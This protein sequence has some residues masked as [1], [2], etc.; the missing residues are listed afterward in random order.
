M[1]TFDQGSTQYRKPWPPQTAVDALFVSGQLSI[2]CLNASHSVRA[3]AVWSL[4]AN[5]CNTTTSCSSQPFRHPGH[6]SSVDNNKNSPGVDDEQALVLLSMT[7]V[8]T[9]GI[10]FP[11][12]FVMLTTVTLSADGSPQSQ[13]FRCQYK[14]RSSQ[15]PQHPQSSLAVATSSSPLGNLQPSTCCLEP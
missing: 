11:R 9:N 5:R 15:R 13:P 7:T 2:S 12:M 1:D 8:T 3:S 14:S 10:S 4:Y 6:P